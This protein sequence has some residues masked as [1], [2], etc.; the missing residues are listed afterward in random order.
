MPFAD[1]DF[2]R[3]PLR[4]SLSPRV[5]GVALFEQRGVARALSKPDSYIVICDKQAGRI[6]AAN[7]RALMEARDAIAEACGQDVINGSLEVHKFLEPLRRAVVEPVM[8]LRVKAPSGYAAALVD[9]LELRGARIWQ[10]DIQ[11]L[12]VVIRAECAL[13]SL[14]G[15]EEEIQTLTNATAVV[16]NWLLRY[17][18][19]RTTVVGTAAFAYPTLLP[20]KGPRVETTRGRPRA[21]WFARAIAWRTA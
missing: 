5:D 14:L 10:Q 4:Q 15:Y 20:P 12:D 3:Y 9:D 21:A 1:H 13:A 6:Y 11:R 8:F 19:S 18:M 7:E 17:D 16:W 2:L